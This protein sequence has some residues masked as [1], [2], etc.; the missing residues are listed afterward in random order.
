MS[1]LTYL[2]ILSSNCVLAMAYFDLGEFDDESSEEH[3]TTDGSSF[4]A[5]EDEDESFRVSNWVSSPPSSPWRNTEDDD[6]VF[7]GALVPCPPP[8]P[9][10]S[11]SDDDEDED[12]TCLYAKW[13]V[14]TPVLAS[15]SALILHENPGPSGI[16]FRPRGEA[17]DAASDDDDEDDDNEDDYEDDDDDEPV[18]KRRRLCLPIPEDKLT[19]ENAVASEDDDFSP[20]FY[21]DGTPRKIKEID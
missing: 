17:A 14:I 21:L 3:W 10:R 9:Q 2:P 1:I 6:V 12:V 5:T 19:L 18:G 20:L 13:F 8:P 16:V 15:S 4:S 11:S 7:V